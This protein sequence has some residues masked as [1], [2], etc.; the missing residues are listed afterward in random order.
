MLS[1][2]TTNEILNAGLEE[3]EYLVYDIKDLINSRSDAE[4][5]LIMLEENCGLYW[6]AD[7]CRKKRPGG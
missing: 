4:D 1:Q 7:I 2:D 5:V 6:A 3:L